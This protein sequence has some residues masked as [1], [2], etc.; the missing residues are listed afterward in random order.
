[1]PVSVFGDRQPRVGI[2]SLALPAH[3]ATVRPAVPWTGSS[4]P[5]MS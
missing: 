2:V 4:A 1:M 5:S 3:D